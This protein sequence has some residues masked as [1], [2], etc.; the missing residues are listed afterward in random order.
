MTIIV[1]FRN[2][3]F[4]NPFKKKVFRLLELIKSITIDNDN[5]FYI[6]LKQPVLGFNQTNSDYDI[7]LIVDEN[8]DLRFILNLFYADL[9]SKKVIIINGDHSY[10]NYVNISS[11]PVLDSLKPGFMYVS[12]LELI[13][14]SIHWIYFNK[15]C[16]E[17]SLKFED[18]VNYFGKSNK[19]LNLSNFFRSKIL[20][21]LFIIKAAL[22]RLN[23]DFF[24]LFIKTIERIERL[25]YPQNKM[26]TSL[27]EKY[28]DIMVIFVNR[29]D[30]QPYFSSKED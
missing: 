18:L 25:T 7:N 28:F 11:I 24:G 27:M 15:Y 13:Q 22:S 30:F 2:K 14:K 23:Y 20:Y 29:Y 1:I 10:F 16:T 26:P 5:D 6:F 9:T 17:N 21:L 12:D 3:Y 19:N 8:I 4:E